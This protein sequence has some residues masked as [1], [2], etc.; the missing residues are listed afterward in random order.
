MREHH[1]GEDDRD[2]AGGEQTEP[3]QTGM[4]G[5]QHPARRHDLG[6]EAEF[7]G[8]HLDGNAG[9]GALW[10][11]AGDADHG[12][13]A[14][15]DLRVGAER[16]ALHRYLRQEQQSRHQSRNFVRPGA[17]L[18]P[19]PHHLL[20]VRNLHDV[21]RVA[22]GA[23]QRHRGGDVALAE[24]Q[25]EMG[26]LRLPVGTDDGDFLDRHGAERRLAHR[27]DRIG[28][29]GIDALRRQFVERLDDQLQAGIGERD[30]A[31]G[32]GRDFRLPLPFDQ[33][34]EPE[35]EC[36]QGGAGQQHADNDRNKI[37]ARESAQN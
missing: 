21:D 13:V 33:P 37:P 5:G 12:A 8:R 16:I 2:N 35:I 29:A 25:A 26:A 31:P 34:V 22:L 3:F 1:E 6:L 4:F 30:R 9:V 7:L 36:E 28:R 24:R 15:G 19:Q 23:D 17:D 10:P 27:I 20:P 11:L 18:A 32:R 14:G